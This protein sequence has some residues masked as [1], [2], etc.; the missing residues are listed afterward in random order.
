MN[1][2]H[3]KRKKYINNLKGN[4]I[5][6]YYNMERKYIAYIMKENEYEKVIRAYVFDKEKGVMLSFED[7]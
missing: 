5:R 6:R 1:K 3:N 4:D 7:G 2:V